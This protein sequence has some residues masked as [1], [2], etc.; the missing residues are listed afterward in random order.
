MVSKLQSLIVSDMKGNDVPSAPPIK[1]MK[2]AIGSDEAM[3]SAEIDDAET[4]AAGTSAA[5][6]MMDRMKTMS[7][8]RAIGKPD[9]YVGL[10]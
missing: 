4:I 6:K 1:N 8:K 7:L 3:K 10:A 9:K 5:V 2:Y